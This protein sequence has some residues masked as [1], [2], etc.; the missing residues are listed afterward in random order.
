MH[1]L[2][3]RDPKGDKECCRGNRFVLSIYTF[4][5]VKRKQVRNEVPNFRFLQDARQVLWERFFDSTSLAV[6]RWMH[7][8]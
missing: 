8:L 7:G 3:E 5:P 2:Q 1:T 6:T 4:L